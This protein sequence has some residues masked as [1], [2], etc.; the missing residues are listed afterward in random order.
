MMKTRPLDDAVLDPP[1]ILMSLSRGQLDY[2]NR[3]KRSGTSSSSGPRCLTFFIALGQA[4]QLNRCAC[5]PSKNFGVLEIISCG[6][7]C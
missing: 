5:Q 2:P 4:G 7:Q 3:G 6:N 1:K